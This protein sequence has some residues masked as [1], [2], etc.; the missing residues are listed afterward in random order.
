M[1]MFKNGVSSNQTSD[2][3]PAAQMPIILSQIQAGGSSE[4]LLVSRNKVSGITVKSHG[5]KPQSFLKETKTSS[6]EITR[7]LNEK[8]IFPARS[9]ESWM[10]I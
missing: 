4:L 10:K 1:Q 7:K 3:P 9:G 6:C 2:F 5:K 8:Q